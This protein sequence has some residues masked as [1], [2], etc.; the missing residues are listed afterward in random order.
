MAAEEA[1]AQNANKVIFKVDWEIFEGVPYLYDS[2][3]NF[4]DLCQ[5]HIV[6]II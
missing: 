6:C 1:A 5:L 3:D 4:S 2:Y